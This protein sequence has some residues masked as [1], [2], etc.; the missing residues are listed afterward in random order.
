M[1]VD[2]PEYA[3]VI[4]EIW[5]VPEDQGNQVYITFQRSFHDTDTLR[6]LCKQAAQLINNAEIEK[7]QKNRDTSRKEVTQSK[8]SSVPQR[9]VKARSVE[10]ADSKPLD[11][12]LAGLINTQIMENWHLPPGLMN[13]DLQTVLFRVLL[14]RN[15]AIVLIQYLD[16]L[17]ETLLKLP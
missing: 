17:D 16:E 13:A 8:A 14:D 2:G 6:N 9:M 7:N 12:D 15:G 5:D 4:E 1:Y 10:G 3:A 11:S